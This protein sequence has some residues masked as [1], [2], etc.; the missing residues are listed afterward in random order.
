MQPVVEVAL[1]E[2]GS[3][4]RRT[5]M[6]ALGPEQRIDRISALRAMT[7]WSAEILLRGDRLGSLEPGKL[8]D[9]VVIDKDYFTIPEPEL[10][11]IK[12]LMTVL[13][14]KI[15]YQAPNF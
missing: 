14:G 7:T 10:M 5:E 9:F 15:A 4:D 8:S 11:N 2:F 12:T 1:G 6:V 13:G 3:G